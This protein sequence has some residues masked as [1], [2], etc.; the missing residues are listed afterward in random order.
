[1]I[2]PDHSIFRTYRTDNTGNN[3]MSHIPYYGEDEKQSKKKT[4]DEKN[5]N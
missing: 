3:S 4:Q 1:M 2:D 5:A